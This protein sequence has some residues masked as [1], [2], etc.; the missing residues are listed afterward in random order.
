M[1]NTSSKS[2]NTWDYNKYYYF[3]F[4]FSIIVIPSNKSLYLHKLQFKNENYEELIIFF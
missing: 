3:K 1:I 2:Y 4:F